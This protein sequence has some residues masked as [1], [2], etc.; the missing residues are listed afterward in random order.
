MRYCSIWIVTLI[1]LASFLSGCG[2]TSAPTESTTNTTDKTT[3]ST[4]DATSSSTP[5]ESDSAAQAAKFTQNNFVQVKTDMANGG[6][7]H[8][9]ALASLLQVPADKR[10]QFFALS[11]EKYTVLY[12]TPSTTP[13]QMLV[14]LN[15]EMNAEM[16]S[17][18]L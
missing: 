6:G 16:G 8:L 7:E 9:T 10:E 17:A 15:L 11:Q 14:R 5:G 4:M 18:S 12:A 13:R 2:T 3:N 1:V